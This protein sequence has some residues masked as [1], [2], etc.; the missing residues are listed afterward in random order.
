MDC[1]S[2]QG[3]CGCYP[4]LKSW[5]LI[6]YF[7]HLCHT[8]WFLSPLIIESI[9]H[10]N[11]TKKS[12]FNSPFLVQPRLLRSA[13]CI[14][15]FSSA[16]WSAL[17]RQWR[18]RCCEDCD[19]SLMMGDDW[20]PTWVWRVLSLHS[21]LKLLNCFQLIFTLSLVTEMQEKGRLFSAE[22]S[23]HREK[24]PS[25]EG[26][27]LASSWSKNSAQTRGGMHS[28]FTDALTQWMA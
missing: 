13:F 27:D 5:G 28:L 22:V 11:E 6:K 24:F 23:L 2:L 4:F 14:L 26:D 1:P 25:H 7:Q 9:D 21:L 18:S 20:S 8:W 12:A 16:S 10:S 3:Q 15:S 19:L 17:H